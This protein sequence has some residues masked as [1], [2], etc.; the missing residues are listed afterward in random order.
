MNEF[1]QGFHVVR[2]FPTLRTVV[3]C[4]LAGS[5]LL[6]AR[7]EDAQA[8]VGRPNI[9][10]IMSDDQAMESMRAMPKTSAWFE[11]NGT[12]FDQYVNTYPLCGP[13]RVTFL[14]GKYAM[15]HGVQSNVAP[16]GGGIRSDD[17]SMLPVWLKQAGY[18]TAFFGKYLNDFGYPDPAY[19]PAGWDRFAGL[20]H[21][22]H[23]SYGFTLLVDGSPLEFG[24]DPSDHQLA[25]LERYA[26]EEI[27][28]NVQER[29]GQPFFLSVFPFAPHE[30]SVPTPPHEGR[31]A[32][33]PLPSSPSFDE[34]DVSDKPSYVARLPRLTE[35]VIASRAAAYRTYLESAASLDNLV[36]AVI[37]E[38][39]RQGVLD[40]TILIF[41]S[42]NGYMYGE[43]RLSS[44]KQFPYEESIR[45]PLMIS[46]PGFRAGERN[47][48]Q[49][50]N[51]DLAPTIAAAAGADAPGV[52][53]MAIQGVLSAPGDHEDR[54]VMIERWDGATARWDNRNS[55][56]CFVG[57]RSARFTYL[58]YYEVNEWELYDREVDP[59][60]LEN[61]A[62]VPEFASV[63]QQLALRIRAL[64]P[65]P[66][67]ECAP[68]LRLRVGQIDRVFAAQQGRV[69]AYIPVSLDGAAP[70][71]QA[72]GGIN[73]DYLITETPEGGAVAG[74]DFIASQGT[75]Q[76]R[77]RQTSGR[78]PVTIL[79]DATGK[80]ARSFEV[81][82]TAARPAVTFINDRGSVRIL[83]SPPS[84]T[85]RL[86]LGRVRTFEQDAWTRSDQYVRV[87]VTLSRP[88][89]VDQT[90]TYSTLEGTARN[91][92]DFRS[93][94]GTVTIPAGSVSTA[95]PA[96]IRSDIDAE[97]AERFVVRV[98][99]PAGS[100][101][102]PGAMSAGIWILD[103]D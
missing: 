32:G 88:L 74:Q 90:L 29:P 55:S 36:D 54:V 79:P 46:G 4:L 65:G 16:K 80:P 60:Q 40:N 45:A 89:P 41:T 47:Q 10:V 18:R 62:G 73:L 30:G 102:T 31:Y 77:Y 35:D 66:L 72:G 103:N 94:E 49:L 64:A 61:L 58:H 99:L 67:P 22:D 8:D 15:N 100:P 1:L 26:V 3:M 56:K 87:P 59:Y 50:A 101:V 91:M 2:P 81:I 28:A 78:I 9:V 63:E 71:L 24:Q 86:D 14:T 75:V 25:V 53:G 92:L 12:I 43:H 69:T 33:E 83:S 42:D 70:R 5:W 39:D 7:H 44:G 68:R 37:S 20:K 85:P 76:I 82:V 52:D 6:A 11:V 95:V 38:L 48:T 57:V 84:E 21:G 97:D 34:D 98:G 51:I 96:A 19:V 17:A 93:V 27:R 23:R 13:S